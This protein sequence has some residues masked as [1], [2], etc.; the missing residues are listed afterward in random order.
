MI[1]LEKGLD[2]EKDLTFRLE[3]VTKTGFRIV[4]QTVM[5][6]EV[7]AD[8]ESRDYLRILDSEGNTLWEDDYI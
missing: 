7:P 8:V 1:T 4:Q 3:L 6:Y 2:L 5:I